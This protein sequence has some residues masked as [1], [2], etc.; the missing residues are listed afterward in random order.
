M[1]SMLVGE[2]PVAPIRCEGRRG[3]HMPIDYDEMMQTGATGLEARYDDKDEKD[4]K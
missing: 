1:R 2:V 4:D 3:Q